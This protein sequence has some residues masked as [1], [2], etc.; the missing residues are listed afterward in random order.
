MNKKRQNGAGLMD[1]LIAL[2]IVTF[3]MVSISGMLTSSLTNTM[4]SEIHFQIKYLSQEMIEQLTANKEAARGGQYNIGFDDADPSGDWIS[5]SL[6]A[7][8]DR[9]RLALPE[10][11]AQ[12]ACTTESCDITLRWMETSDNQFY[13]LRS[14]I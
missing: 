14:P 3:G 2:V 11:A 13:R 12:I 4:Y 9:V 5:D 10:G 8:K 7:W 6:T 1:A